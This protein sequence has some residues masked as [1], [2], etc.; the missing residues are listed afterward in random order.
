M[1]EV[2]VV[3]PTGVPLISCIP[4]MVMQVDAE[5]RQTADEAAQTFAPAEMAGWTS[6]YVTAFI[7]YLLAIS[8]LDALYGHT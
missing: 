8:L 7:D 3:E 4:P 1:S 2:D 5:T 6:D